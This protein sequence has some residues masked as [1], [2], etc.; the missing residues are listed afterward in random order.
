MSGR[1]VWTQ[2]PLIHR[3][4]AGIP[5]VNAGHMAA[6]AVGAAKVPAIVLTAVVSPCCSEQWWVDWRSVG[7]RR[8]RRQERSLRE[9]VREHRGKIRVELRKP[10]PDDR[11]I[12][13][14][15]RE[16]RAFEKG[17]ERARKRSKGKG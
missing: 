9:R 13:Y 3:L 7:K 15:E 14:W 11:L 6:A 17:I 10:L 5:S 8:Y 1:E 2:G 4:R 16:I 12:R